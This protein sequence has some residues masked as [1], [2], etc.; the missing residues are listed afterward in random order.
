MSSGWKSGPITVGAVDKLPMKG[1]SLLLGNDIGE[2]LYIPRRTD[3]KTKLEV[4][5]RRQ[6]EGNAGQTFRR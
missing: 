2:E 4:R 6:R 3:D 5:G 1:I